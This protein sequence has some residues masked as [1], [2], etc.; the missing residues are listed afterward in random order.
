MAGPAD[1]LLSK[2]RLY[3]SELDSQAGHVVRW[4]CLRIGV[5]HDE[6][7]LRLQERAMRTRLRQTVLQETLRHALRQEDGGQEGRTQKAVI[8]IGA[9]WSAQRW[10][11]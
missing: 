9:L 5:Y 11:G 7:G 1:K 8:A 10:H 4:T 3:E 2:E 6:L